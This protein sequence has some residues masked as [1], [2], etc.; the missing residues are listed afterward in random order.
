VDINVLIFS[1]ILFAYINLESEQ[2]QPLNFIIIDQCISV[3]FYR[4]WKL[5]K[6]ILSSNLCY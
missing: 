1:I 3:L 4:I 6:Y 5:K 2:N